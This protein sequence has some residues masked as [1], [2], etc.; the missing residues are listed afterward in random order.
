MEQFDEILRSFINE[1]L[2]VENRFGKI[3]DEEKMLAIKKLMLE[4]LLNLRFLGTTLNYEELVVALENITIDRLSTAS[5]TR[6]NKIDTSGH[7]EI[8]MTAKD[9]SESS[10][11]EADQRILDNALQDVCEGTGK[12]HWV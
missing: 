2:K 9:D 5:A 8:G 7:M 1:T 4:S 6:Q 10:R 12:A 11:E 3:T